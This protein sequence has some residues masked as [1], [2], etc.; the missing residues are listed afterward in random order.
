MVL[1][2]LRLEQ[3]T[4]A[5]VGVRQRGHSCGHVDYFMWEEFPSYRISMNI[6]NL[7]LIFFPIREL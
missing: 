6:C 1:A 2:Y 4:N 3:S 7:S 5:G